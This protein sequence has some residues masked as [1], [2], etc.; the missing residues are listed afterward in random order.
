MLSLSE[1]IEGSLRDIERG[2][3]NFLSTLDVDE[4]HQVRFYYTAL[5]LWNR[6]D[7][8]RWKSAKLALRQQSKRKGIIEVDHIVACQLWDRKL[9]VLG[10]VEDDEKISELATKINELGNC[11]LLEKNFN[12]SK[13]DKPLGDFL[14]DIHEFQ[15]NQLTQ[16]EWAAALALEMEQ[17]DCGEVPADNLSR[18]I[19][20]R[21]QK[22]RDDLERF[23]R[24]ESHRID[25][26]DAGG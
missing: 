18:L 7:K 12:I 1:Q 6:L 22:I 10:T 23:V 4:R 2:A 24:G 13:S 21:T 25:L 9:K 5:W 16:N 8:K 15:T 26:N 17:V 14:S 20:A 11:M 3:V 19:S